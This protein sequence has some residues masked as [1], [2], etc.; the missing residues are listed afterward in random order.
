MLPKFLFLSVFLLFFALFTYYGIKRFIYRLLLPKLAIRLLTALAIVNF[1]L[2]VAYMFYRGYEEKSDLLFYTLSIA[3]GFGF[4]LFIFALSYE[5]IIIALIALKHLAF[6]KYV[7]LAIVTLFFATLLY[8]TLNQLRGTVLTEVSID[9]PM[10]D[11]PIDAV[12]ISDL[13]I[14]GLVDSAY[15]S[16][17]VDKINTLHPDMVFLVGDII[18][19]TPKNILQT[20]D[21]LKKIEAKQGVFFVLG[22]HEMFHSPKYWMEYFSKIGFN[23]LVNQNI[24]LHIKGEEINIVGLSDIFG[25][26]D[27]QIDVAKSFQGAQEGTTILLAHQPQSIGL[28][29]NQKADLVLSGHTH[30]GQ[31]Y[32]FGYIVKLKQPFI[33][34]L[35]E[36]ENI[37]KVFVSSGAGFWGPPMRIGS[38]SEIVHFRLY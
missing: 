36:V 38:K 26:E 37:G 25:K 22:N 19:D 6:K 14:G 27:L 10:L 5:L 18:D 32:P 35:H 13:H 28:L 9:L 2:V 29:Q 20:V 31:I 16:D 33:Y 23:V 11:T 1:F 34:G 24:K 8:G 12:M 7:D 21:L 17:T 4:L 15:V 3:I 30:G